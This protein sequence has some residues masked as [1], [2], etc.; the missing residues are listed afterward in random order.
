MLEAVSAIAFGLPSLHQIYNA[1]LPL[2]FLPAGQGTQERN[3]YA[4]KENWRGEKAL[5]DLVIFLF[6]LVEIYFWGWWRQSDC[7][8]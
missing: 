8:T 5:H 6:Q 7:K 2:S 4:K 3:L 1:A